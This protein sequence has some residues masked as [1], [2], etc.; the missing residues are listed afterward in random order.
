[1][2]QD[3][4]LAKQPQTRTFRAAQGALCTAAAT[5]SVVGVTHYKVWREEWQDWRTKSAQQS[6]L[7]R[8]DQNPLEFAGFREDPTHRITAPIR[9]D[10]MVRRGSP[11]FGHH[12]ALAWNEQTLLRNKI[13]LDA[14][15]AACDQRPST[16][17]PITTAFRRM[18]KT[19]RSI[20]DPLTQA[21]MVNAWVNA[22]LTYDTGELK[23]GNR[24]TLP[25]AL[26]TKHS[27]CDENAQLKYYALH[28][29]GVAPENV[30]I[31]LA[32][33]TRDGKRIDNHAFL[34][35]RVGSTNWVLSNQQASVPVA[36]Q[37]H[38]ASTYAASE[39][40]KIFDYDA[41]MPVDAAFA[42]IN[43]QASKQFGN[44]E[45]IPNQSITYTAATPYAGVHD[46]ITAPFY[47]ATAHKPKPVKTRSPQDFSLTQAL[48][49]LPDTTRNEAYDV[50]R[51]TLPTRQPAAAPIVSNPIRNPTV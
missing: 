9:V 31:V 8:V 6:T 10:P 4:H 47:G 32:A 17:P 15:F 12:A 43:H 19:A 11:T 29:I 18:I 30:R 37:P 13:E 28:K 2:H 42:N 34:V 16:C 25:Q 22:T 24:R 5:I 40:K 45:I 38:T 1:M 41:A 44:R 27:V 20:H 35:L 3:D 26:E 14:V 39:L 7:H 50:L 36:T 51:D 48:N 46:R 23:A 21:G 49:A 33:V